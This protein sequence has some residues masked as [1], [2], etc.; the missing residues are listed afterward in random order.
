[1]SP[2]RLIT[3]IAETGAFLLGNAHRCGVADE[4]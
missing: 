3:R 2:R 4:R 1:V